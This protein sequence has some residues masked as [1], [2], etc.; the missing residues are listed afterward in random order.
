M[1]TEDS[2]QILTETPVTA[3]VAASTHIPLQTAKR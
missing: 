1:T 2:V 3:L